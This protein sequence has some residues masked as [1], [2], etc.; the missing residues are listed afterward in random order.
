MLDAFF[1]WLRIALSSFGRPAGQIELMHRALVDERKWVR[2]TVSP[3]LEFRW[4]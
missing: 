4:S 1:V 3:R 2:R